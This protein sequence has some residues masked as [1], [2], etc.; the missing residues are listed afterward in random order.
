MNALRWLARCY[1][2]P[3]SVSDDLRRALVF[4]DADVEGETVV[5]AGYGAAFLWLL[6][7]PLAFALLPRSV[8]FLVG[9]SLL[10]GSLAAAHCIHRAPIVLALIR[11]TGALGNAPN[12]V[13]R[14]VLRMRIEPTAETAAAFA[15]RTGDG[16]LAESLSDHVRRARGTADTGFASFAT[17]WERWHPSLRRALSLVEAAADAPTGE[18]GRTLD[19][20]LDAVLDGTRNRMAAF[21]NE[22]RG[23][24]TG[25]YAFGVLLPLAL[26]AVFPAARVAGFHVT[27]VM[28]VVAYDAVLPV[29]LVATGCWLLVRRPAAFPPPPVKRAHPAVPDARWRPIAGGVAVGLLAWLIVGFVLPTWTRWLA[30]VGFTSGVLLVALSRPIKTVRDHV[31][32][33]EQRLTDALYLL[34]RRIG[35][36]ESVETAVEAVSEQID[37]ETG[38]VFAAAAWRQRQLRTG[39]EE[40]FL[41]EYGALADVPSPRARSTARLLAVAAREGRPAGRAVVAMADHLDDLAEVEREARH[42]LAHVT[43]TLRSTAAAFGP[44]VAGSTVALADGMAV[45]DGFRGQTTGI[46]TGELGVVVGVYVLLLAAILTALAVGLDRG[47]DR[48]LVGYRVGQALCSAT[49]V[50][51]GSFAV[52][53]MLL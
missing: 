31:R 53:G 47:F 34:G 16:P 43:G 1:P 35:K 14:A 3:V 26:V 17:E 39:V 51:L 5:R 6:F 23:P 19:R 38:A 44:L 11:R 8:R 30:L 29:F 12:I 10:A 2:W 37:G 4:L 27:T 18:R 36:G 41:G 48:A 42:E 45:S 40:S 25:L 24:A 21:A 20:A 49:V 13:G 9:L 22:I 15:A 50:Y 46:P 52:A 32:D 7:A 33:V 28:L